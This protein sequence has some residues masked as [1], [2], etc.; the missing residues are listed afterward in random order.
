MINKQELS[1]IRK[2]ADDILADLRSL[3]QSLKTEEQ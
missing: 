2:K 1:N 3:N